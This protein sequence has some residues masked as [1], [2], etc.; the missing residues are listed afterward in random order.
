[1][2]QDSPRP[3]LTTASPEQA[4]EHMRRALAS[5]MECFVSFAAGD[6]AEESPPPAPIQVRPLADGEED[7]PGLPASPSPRT[8]SRLLS[9][10][11]RQ[12]LSLGQQLGQ[13]LDLLRLRLGA[14]VSGPGGILAMT[15]AGQPAFNLS[16]GI[17]QNTARLLFQR[18]AALA[19]GEI[20]L[21]ALG[22]D[23]YVE[24]IC[25]EQGMEWFLVLALNGQRRP[26]EADLEWSG[27]MLNL[28][29][30]T[31]R[32]HRRDSDLMDLRA[33]LDT[34]FEAVP[35]PVL[36]V[37]EG[38]VTGV[39]GAALALLREQREQVVGSELCH[40]LPP[41]THIHWPGSQIP[42]QTGGSLS[43]ACHPVWRGGRQ[44]TLVVL[45]GQPVAAG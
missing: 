11:D 13:V 19:P 20:Y 28:C 29:R 35:N 26:D 30:L 42:G 40:I 23:W 17:E 37:A 34:L 32:N 2:R 14:V 21:R 8:L 38:R 25:Q 39:N 9:S 41:G 24:R 1:M 22:R 3:H 44:E 5:G 36:T 27:L 4:L 18:F 7:A 15:G 45:R 43:A 16:R 33:L 10:L 12:D 6:D 31:L